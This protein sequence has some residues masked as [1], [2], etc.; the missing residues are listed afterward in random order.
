MLMDLVERTF[1]A[2]NACS[3]WRHGMADLKTRVLRGLVPGA[4]TASPDLDNIV[5][6]GLL[7]SPTG[8]GQSA[9]LCSDAIRDIG[10][11]ISTVDLCPQFKI[12]GNVAFDGGAGSP[13]AGSGILLL[14]VNAPQV[15]RALWHLDRALTRDKL[16]VGCWAW[17]LERT[18]PDWSEGARCVHEI[19]APSRFAAAAMAG[20][21]P[22]RPVRIVPHVAAPAA[23]TG[24]GRERAGAARA[25]L[26]LPGAAFVAAY[27]FSMLSG[28]ERKNPLG[29]VVAF[30]QA[31]GDDPDAV[32][33]LRCLDLDA[34]PP[35]A[36]RLRSEIARSVNIR[37]LTQASPSM[38]TVIEAAD[39]YLSLHRSE[40]FGLTLIEAMAAGKPVVATG[41]SGNTDFMSGD[42]SVLI[43]SGLVAVEDPQGIYRHG[44]DKWADPSI[45][46]TAAALRRLRR[47]GA[48]R[49]ALGA[50][51]RAAAEGFAERG[52]RDLR[53]AL[54]TCA[55][56]PAGT[57]ATVAPAD[58]GMANDD[59]LDI[60][61]PRQC[62]PCGT[63]FS[64]PDS[65]AWGDRPVPSL[66]RAA[67]ASD[68]TAAAPLALIDQLCRQLSHTPC[69]GAGFTQTRP[70]DYR[71]ITD[72]LAAAFERSRAQFSRRNQPVID[73]FLDS[74]ARLDR[75]PIATYPDEALRLAVLE[76]QMLLECGE[77]AR[78]LAS[79]AHVAQ[80]PY[81]VE[82]DLG[83]LLGVLAVH[84]RALLI[85][86]RR[87]EAARA[88][89]RDLHFVTGAAPLRA[90]AAFALFSAALHVVPAVGVAREGL[91]GAVATL[92]RLRVSLDR[93]SGSLRVRLQRR[94]GRLAVDWLGGRAVAALALA[95]RWLTRLPV[96]AGAPDPEKGVLV[97]RAMGGVGDLIM[98]TPGL[99]ALA[100]KT[101]QPVH[102][103]IRRSF[104]PIFAD[105]PD[106]ILHD[107]DARALETETFRRSHNLSFCPCGAYESRRR[108]KV[109][110]GRVEL[111]ARGM[112]VSDRALL[113]V[114][115][116][117][118]LFLSEASL[119]R[120][121]A[122]LAE[123]G[124]DGSEPVI[125]VQPFSRDTYKDYPRMERLI[126][127]L[128][129]RFKVVV[130][131]HL[132]CRVPRQPNV[133][134]AFGQPLADAFATF[135]KCD[136]AVCGDSAFLHVAAALDIPTVALFGPTDGRTFTMHHPHA[137][138]VSAG[139]AFR[140]VP[141]WRNEDTPCHLTGGR[142]S[143]CL[144]AIDE[145]EVVRIVEAK[146]K[147]ER[148][149]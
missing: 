133:V 62:P 73:A 57:R 70:S 120:A 26:G 56:A 29:A 78:A 91:A 117:P 21:V 54:A 58:D 146:L 6:A 147:V 134:P 103:A 69:T 98:M 126:E 118:R 101:R 20:S 144:A 115:L 48:L 15:P 84:Q 100:R 64:G 63:P 121:D 24:D 33:V 34:Y 14:H 39:I 47:D 104:F 143:A 80:R 142:E 132:A 46:A 60:S 85:M 108:P 22:G 3:D 79:I 89:W 31:F 81:L 49:V 12:P 75:T 68:P 148:A 137:T 41:W 13:R 109:R 119:Q 35:G 99:R 88:A 45:A 116:K 105:N 135:S 139:S 7:S 53:S 129:A 61:R 90:A 44:E 106:V 16:I 123:H 130:F 42:D 1:S 74:I 8:L 113:S 5:V 50:R 40:G 86:G 4:G 131:H 2:V 96:P 18:P 87:D 23:P 77:A 124:L 28:F 94:I 95:P 128:S 110:K 136:L 59:P 9:R 102:L 27:G 66:G 17:E 112:G 125:G 76:A 71:R 111:F 72:S 122:F 52:R 141:C 19:W 65:L 138:V 145:A 36:A 92:A 83:L 32:L 93:G 51:A 149:A 97:T 30:R 140:C 25:A 43:E 55:G 11:R 37:L 114:D 38:R 67:G 127:R 107:I 10:Y 82:G